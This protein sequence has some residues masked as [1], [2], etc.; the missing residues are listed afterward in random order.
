MR[1][2]FAPL[3]LAAAGATRPARW[4]LVALGIAL[5]SSATGVAAEFHG[6]TEAIVPARMCAVFGH[7]WGELPE[8]GAQLW[9]CRPRNEHLGRAPSWI[10][11]QG[12][13]LFP[14]GPAAVIS[15]I[16]VTVREFFP[17]DAHLASWTGLCPGNHES[18]GR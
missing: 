18:A 15:E 8:S 3:M 11:L 10:P 12:Q 2:G 7:G 1:D 16:G 5:G 17:G 14:A 9:L 4:L 13:R 6:P